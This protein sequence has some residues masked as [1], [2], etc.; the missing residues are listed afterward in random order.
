M[1]GMAECMAEDVLHAS[2]I[3]LSPATSLGTT[4]F[5]SAPDPWPHTHAFPPYDSPFFR[6]LGA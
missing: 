3:K 4:I 1:L 5:T 6:G 2:F